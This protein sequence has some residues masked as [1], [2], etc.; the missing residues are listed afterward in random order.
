MNEKFIDKVEGFAKELE[1][2]DSAERTRILT[3]ISILLISFCFIVFSPLV[4]VLVLVIVYEFIMI[5]KT[6]VQIRHWVKKRK[7]DSDKF[8][9]KFEEHNQKRL[10]RCLKLSSIEEEI[11]SNCGKLYNSYSSIYATSTRRSSD[12]LSDSI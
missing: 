8:Y 9:S 3:I 7:E 12:E 5:L 2:M 11:D 10:S 6:E 1:E 4:A